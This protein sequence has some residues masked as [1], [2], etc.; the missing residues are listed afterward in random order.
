[1]KRCEKS[2]SE[3]K[4]N[5]VC[6]TSKEISKTLQENNVSVEVKSNYYTV[7]SVVAGEYAQVDSIYT[8]E[9]G[10]KAIIPKGWTVSGIQK[11]NT[12]WGENVGLVIYCI[13]KEKINDINWNN[14]EELE[15]LKQKYDQYVWIPIGMIKKNG[16]QDGVSFEKKLGRRFYRKE[17]NFKS[18]YTELIP[19]E[20]NLKCEKLEKYKGFY[21]SRYNISKNSETGK[22]QSVKGKIPWTNIMF[23]DALNVANTL[24]KSE[25]IQTHLTY[26][27]EHD[28]T[29]EWIIESNRNDW[30]KVLKNSM[31]YVK[32]LSE[33]N[34]QRNLLTTGCMQEWCINNIYDLKGN[35]ANWTQEK[36]GNS[37]YAV[38][39]SR[40]D[41]FEQLCPVVYRTFYNAHDTE[42]LLG[43]RAVMSININ[44]IFN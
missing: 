26:G 6:E 30:K 29:I 24:Q 12:I 22:P 25:T 35:V 31:G 38:R 2:V 10:N 3:G 34:F 32:Y 40:Y 39:G 7:Q 23:F 33:K 28:S 18:Q 21:I 19:S 5:I 36:S 13:P 11:E 44:K 14:S 15:N 20:F 37:L 41:W 4:K 16:T 9:N 8:D 42:N 43:F 27:V 1:M 17:E